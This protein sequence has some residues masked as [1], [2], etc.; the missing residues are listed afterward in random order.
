LP[1][2]AAKGDAHLLVYKFEEKGKTYISIKQLNQNER[3]T[4]LAKMVGGENFSDATLKTA[5]EL[6]KG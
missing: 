6:L 1:Q 4:E 2:V 3:I 5:K